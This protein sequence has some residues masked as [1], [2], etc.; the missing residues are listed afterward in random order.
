MWFAGGGFFG[1]IDGHGWRQRQ[2]T[3]ALH[4]LAQPSD[5]P[6]EFSGWGFLTSF[7]DVG[8]LKGGG[9]S[10]FVAG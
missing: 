10:L 4:K 8:F 9:T 3:A 5:G 1:L 2:R 7:Q 6:Q